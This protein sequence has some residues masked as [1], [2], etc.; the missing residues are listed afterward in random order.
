MK[1]VVVRAGKRRRSEATSAAK[2][3]F[4]CT[5]RQNPRKFLLC[6]PAILHVQAS[7]HRSKRLAKRDSTHPLRSSTRPEVIRMFFPA[8]S[9]L[10]HEWGLLLCLVLFSTLILFQLSGSR[11]GRFAV[12]A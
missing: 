7:Y 5:P 6:S 1:A 2:S 4:G 3:T 12:K 10:R 8:L 9:S 11:V